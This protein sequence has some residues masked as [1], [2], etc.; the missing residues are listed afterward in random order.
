[1][2]F[3]SHHLKDSPYFSTMWTLSIGRLL[4][5]QKRSFRK[6]PVWGL[7]DAFEKANSILGPPIRR[8]DSG[9]ETFGVE[10]D[11]QHHIV[12]GE[13]RKTGGLEAISVGVTIPPVTSQVS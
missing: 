1:M 2:A 6:S 9:E 13:F 3:H 10:W 11:L 12:F 4:P 5:N 8:D 7:G